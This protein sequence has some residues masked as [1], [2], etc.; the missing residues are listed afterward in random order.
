M[1]QKRLEDKIMSMALRPPTH[2]PRFEAME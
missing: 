2:V 1:R